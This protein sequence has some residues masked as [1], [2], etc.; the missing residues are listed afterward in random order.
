MTTFPLFDTIVG[1]L[2]AAPSPLSE[3]TKTALIKDIKSFNKDAHEIVYAL[4][5]SY[6]R[7]YEKQ[8]TVVGL[9]YGGKRLRKG[10]KFDIDELPYKLQWIL[11]SF[12]SLHM[13]RQEEGALDTPRAGKEG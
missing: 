12:A 4:I 11:F 3:E 10:A 13:K 9:P 7:T 2:E 1:G 8:P 5:K 6:D